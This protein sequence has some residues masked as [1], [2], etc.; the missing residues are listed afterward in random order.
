MQHYWSLDD[1]HLQDSWVTIGS[2][3]GVHRGHQAIVHTLTAGAHAA[4]AP[5]VVLTFHPHPAVV[6]GGRQGPFYL[7]TPEERAA[8]LGELGVDVVVSFPFN[9]EVAQM[10]AREF[11]SLLSKH[12]KLSELWVG[13]DFA[14]GRGRE[15]T[16]PVLRQIGEE[17]GYRVE[18]IAPI[19]IDGQIISSSQIR[20]ALMEG[21]VE[22]AAQMLGRPYR[23][24]GPV[25]TGDSRGRTIGI[26]TANLEVPN[27]RVL[28]KAG[29]YACQ[30]FHNGR[31][32]QAVT[33]VGFRPTFENQPPT[34]RVEAH[35]LDF[36]QD[37]YG[38][39]LDLTFN[40][41][42]RDEQRFPGVEA[43]VRQ[44]HEDIERA[45]TILA[46]SEA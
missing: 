31:T 16:V 17:L 43:L 40:A 33:N 4:G 34:P 22:K 12:L 18:Q 14:L 15:G 37:L 36:D 19:E 1:V 29:V 3:D 11:M 2:F 21:E 9:R 41:R 8:I 5:A 20:S 39:N 23:I 32:Y 44:I 25:V 45:R 38:Q 13:Y 10:T 27:E 28:P 30:A 42:L 35:L 46:N 24:G 26:P 7:T 6:L